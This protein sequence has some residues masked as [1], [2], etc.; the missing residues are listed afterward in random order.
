MSEQSAEQ[1]RAG[2]VRTILAAEVAFGRGLPPVPCQVK[3]LSDTGARIIVDEA[4]LLPNRFELR[5]PRRK[6]THQA[7]VRWRRGALLGLEFIAEEAAPP[8]DPATRIR[9]LE[10]ENAEL[11]RRV[12]DMAERLFNYGESEL[13]GKHQD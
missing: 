10:A 6:V 13:F 7:Q 11:R 8:A 3:D 9:E 12:A 5:V 2:R 4:V 1:R